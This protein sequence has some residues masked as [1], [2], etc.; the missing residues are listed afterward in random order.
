MKSQ[1]L[2]MQNPPP[3][4]PPKDRA[5][6][7]LTML[8]QL[9]PEKQNEIMKTVIQELTI[10]RINRYRVERDRHSKNCEDFLRLNPEMFAKEYEA[11]NQNKQG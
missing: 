10:D 3:P 9:E 7:L 2:K 11:N 4:P 8:R 1:A 6:E 5:A